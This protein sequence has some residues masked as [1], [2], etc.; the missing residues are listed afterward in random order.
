MFL[1]F[2]ILTG[3]SI[4]TDKLSTK[5]NL[6]QIKEKIY[7]IKSFTVWRDCKVHC[8]KTTKKLCI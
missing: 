7:L 5:K 6:K 2:T 1:K 4:K 3:L 8:I